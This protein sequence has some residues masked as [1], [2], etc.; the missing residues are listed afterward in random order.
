MTQHDIIVAPATMSGGAIAIIRLS[1]EGSIELVDNFFSPRNGRPLAGAK[2]HTIHYGE[3]IDPSN[4]II[5]DVLVSVFRAPHSYTCE[6]GVEIS[7]HGSQY[8]VQQ[9]ISLSLRHGARLAEAGEFTI[10]AYLAGRMDLSQAEAVAD[11]IAASS[12]ASH[13]MA[14]TQMRGGYSSQLSSLRESLLNLVTL[15]ELELD[16]SEEDV[17]FADRGKLR[18]LMC[19]IRREITRLESSF[20]V[21]NAIKNGVAVAI[22]GEPNAGKSTL[23]NRLLN[24]DRAMVSDIAGTTRDIIEESIIIDGITY[25]FIDTAGIHTT[26]DKLEQMGIERSFR[27]INRAQIVIQL[28]DGTKGSFTPIE[29]SEDQT[30]IIVRNKVD[31]ICDKVDLLKDDLHNTKLDPDFESDK[32]SNDI[33]NISARKNIGIEDLIN[34]LQSSLNTDSLYAGDPIVSSARHYDHL[35]HAN[36]SLSSA[37]VALADGT[38]T[39]LLC[40]EIRQTLHHI[41]SIT[42][43]IS[44]DDIL[45]NIFSNFCIGK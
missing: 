9:I 19:E 18:D 35:H 11:M 25:R 4:S 39:D 13:R 10:R 16:F 24:D 27:A 5:D 14:S 1:G 41:G 33:I 29:V 40:E 22:I 44:T 42:G 17:E 23:L 45:G 28:I 34:K 30:L 26:E 36:D 20:K 7:C 6:D 2:G 15:L 21:G 31:L 37:L 12:E 32:K 8:I 3:I 43:E 38:P